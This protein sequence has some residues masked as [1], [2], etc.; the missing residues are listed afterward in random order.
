MTDEVDVTCTCCGRSAA[1]RFVGIS[2]EPLWSFLPSHGDRDLAAVMPFRIQI[3]ACEECGDGLE[4]E[5]RAAGRAG[6]FLRDTEP[7]PAAEV[8]P[9]HLWPD[10]CP[11]CGAESGPEDYW[12]AAH[13]PTA[14]YGTALGHCY[15]CSAPHPVLGQLRAPT[16]EAETYEAARESDT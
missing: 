15:E 12:Y 6:A 8:W 11:R 7:R 13:P 16:A 1:G 2:A 14:V 4:A 10:A 3:D 9:A 5:A